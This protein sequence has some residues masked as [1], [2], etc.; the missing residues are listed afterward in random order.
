M[1]TLSLPELPP[2]RVYAAAAKYIEGTVL[3]TFLPTL[4]DYIQSKSQICRFHLLAA[5][6]RYKA[7][8]NYVAPRPDLGPVE[9]DILSFA[10]SET[11]P[12]LL[13]LVGEM[14]SGKTTT[15][16]YLVDSFLASHATIK[17]PSGGGRVI[18]DR[19]LVHIDFDKFLKRFEADRRETPTG[20]DE[21]SVLRDTAIEEQLADRLEAEL[22]DQL[23]PPEEF[24]DMWTWAFSR[25]D[26]NEHPALICL[27]DIREKLRARHPHTWRTSA[28]DVVK[29]RMDL[30][31]GRYPEMD[32]LHKLLYQLLRIDYITTAWY[33]GR[34]SSFLIVFDNLDP[35]PPVDQHR[36]VL[37]AL[38]VGEISNCRIILS[39]RPLTYV[40]RLQGAQTVVELVEHAGPDAIDLIQSR[41]RTHIDALSDSL[42]GERLRVAAGSP[43]RGAAPLE[44]TQH[45]DGEWYVHTALGETPMRVIRGWLDGVSRTLGRNLSPNAQTA[46][47]PSLRYFLAGVSGYSL[48]TALLLSQKIAATHLLSQEEIGHRL[49]REGQS[50]LSDWEG[51]RAMLLARRDVYIPMRNRVI[52]N[53]F[54]AG[55]DGRRGDALCKLRILQALANEPGAAKARTLNELR[56]Y[57][58]LF[59]YDEV[60]LLDAL[61]A[62]VAQ[63]KR[64]CWCTST[65]YL[66]NLSWY[67]NDEI[68][69]AAA[70]G[71]YLNYAVRSFDYVVEMARA[72]Q[73]ARGAPVDGT[74]TDLSRM[75]RQFVIELAEADKADVLTAK[76]L[77]RLR[78][79]KEV[80][81]VTPLTVPVGES[82]YR[83]TDRQLRV[84]IHKLE[85]DDRDRREEVASLQGERASWQNFT[86]PKLT[87]LWKDIE[88]VL[89]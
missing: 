25:Q 12:R 8:D 2:N 44:V 38:R 73:F 16:R 29:S 70:G 60:V 17:H 49:G 6:T 35:L 42:L 75:L 51:I 47:Q 11:A 50:V 74:L 80:A 61:N 4:G 18:R 79:Y 67:G 37:T 54:T 33:G 78:S 46:G 7:P 56:F 14:G 30:F 23:E 68:H 5:H 36:I 81:G 57:I 3:S 45:S 34:S 63:T 20:V 19:M 53:V 43:A 89:R 10:V 66:E 71:F 62:L 9:R 58:S 82:L 24:A 40:S 13:V 41:I 69:L 76:G 88:D 28:E 27:A 21:R 87:G 52:D 1:G 85:A 86:M 32:L 39:L 64:L 31:Y 26:Y 15:L 77:N 65:V 48:R 55:H 83:K 84:T 22:T 72:L 59:E